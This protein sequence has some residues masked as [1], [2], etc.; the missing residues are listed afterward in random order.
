VKERPYG[1]TGPRAQN[2]CTTGNVLEYVIDWR[3]FH[4]YTVSYQTRLLSMLI[5]GELE[6]VAR[7]ARV[8][9]RM[10]FE[11]P[12]PWWLLSAIRP[13][14]APWVR[15]RIEK[16]FQKVELLMGDTSWQQRAG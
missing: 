10:K 12:L 1:R 4:Y 3:P 9:W 2:H 7:G 16:G 14:A 13:F 11:S 8:R 6:P 15:E 5:T